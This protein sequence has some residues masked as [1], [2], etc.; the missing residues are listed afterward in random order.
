MSLNK[1]DAQ[2]PDFGLSIIL[3][4][5]NE[6]KNLIAAVDTCLDYLK[7]LPG[8]HELIIIDDGST[9]ETPEIARS[10]QK[11]HPGIRVVTHE[12]NMGMGAGIRT[13]IMAATKP[14]FE[15][16]PADGQ[17]PPSE[18]DKLLHL[19]PEADFVISRYTAREDG[20]SRKILSQGF[21]LAMRLFLGGYVPLQGL[22]VF[23]TTVAQDIVRAGRARSHS[24]LFSFE[25][26]QGGVKKG[27]RYGT[28]YIQCTPRLVGKSKVANV[29]TIVKILQELMEGR[30][31]RGRV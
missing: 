18:T 10:L 7:G 12:V 29:R 25:L 2:K 17:I 24:F 23:P 1:P 15:A 22:Y 20:L 9:D 8:D 31:D 26:L 11:E 13:G 28:A 30:R 16:M 14:F 6:E 21:R 5:Y 27:L 3:L 4:A 19:L